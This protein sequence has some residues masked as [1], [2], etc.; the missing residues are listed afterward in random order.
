MAESIIKMTCQ[1]YRISTDRDG[2]GKLILEFGSDSSMAV[3]ELMA[4]SLNGDTNLAVAIVP[5][6]SNMPIN[7][8]EL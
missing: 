8:I 1:L 7:E 2:G 5:I 6:R 3:Q 4:V